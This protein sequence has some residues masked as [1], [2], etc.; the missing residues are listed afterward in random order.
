MELCLELGPRAAS[1]SRRVCA[2]GLPPRASPLG[3]RG[4]KSGC[5]KLS[6]G[7]G[8]SF[9]LVSVGSSALCEARALG[10]GTVLA[11]SAEL[12]LPQAMPAQGNELSSCGTS[13]RFPVRSA[14]G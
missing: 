12:G 2:W 8:D 10:P 14:P 11:S 5:V 4:C 1:G 13:E 7:G 3:Q 6:Q 9:I